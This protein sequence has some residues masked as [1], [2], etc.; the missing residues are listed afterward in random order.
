MAGAKAHVFAG[1]QEQEQEQKKR[2][3]NKA[4]QQ[5]WHA[6]RSALTGTLEVMGV[7]RVKAGMQA[8]HAAELWR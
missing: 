2:R 6:C 1:P 8:R 5:T 7:E 3:H 4:L